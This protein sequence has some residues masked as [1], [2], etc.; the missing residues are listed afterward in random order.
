MSIKE[1]RSQ[2]SVASNTAR[3]ETSYLCYSCPSFGLHPFD[4]TVAEL[5]KG[6]QTVETR[7]VADLPHDV[8]GVFRVF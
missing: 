3:R 4:C 5:F 7:N 8:S 1:Y 2:E 6:P